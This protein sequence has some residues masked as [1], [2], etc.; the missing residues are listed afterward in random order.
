MLRIFLFLA[1]VAPAMAAETNFTCPSNRP[2]LV[3]VGTGIMTCTLL[4]CVGPLICPPDGDCVRAPAK[5][6]NSCQE[7]KQALCLTD[8]ELKA[9][10]SRFP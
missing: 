6:C 10:R 5:D 8:E 9:A 7:E 4:A 2:N 3:T 1:M